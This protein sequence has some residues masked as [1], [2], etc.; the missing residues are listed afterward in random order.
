MVCLGVAL[1]RRS[2]WQTAPIGRGKEHIDSS[3]NT[4]F[5]LDQRHPNL[6]CVLL[7]FQEGT[8]KEV[9]IVLKYQLQRVTKGTETVGLAVSKTASHGGSPSHRDGCHCHL[10]SG[11]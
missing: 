1:S 11:Y 3:F 7:T 5:K 8:P 4:P 9:S 6:S 10:T 2:N